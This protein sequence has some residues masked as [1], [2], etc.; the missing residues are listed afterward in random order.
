MGTAWRI[1]LRINLVGLLILLLPQVSFRTE[2]S[3]TG[4]AEAKLHD[5]QLV[6]CGDPQ[7]F[8]SLAHGA[9]R[10]SLFPFTVRLPVFGIVLGDI[11][12]YQGFQIIE[13]G[14]LEMALLNFPDSCLD[15]KIRIIS[16]QE[17]YPP[18]IVLG[19]SHAFKLP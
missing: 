7:K 11:V 18:D 12:V 8:E 16:S 2:A 6:S 14:E 9:H 5:L 10:L 4:A 17:M 19:Y 1:R 3:T 13:R 15:W